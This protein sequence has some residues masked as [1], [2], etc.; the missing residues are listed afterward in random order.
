M[1]IYTETIYTKTTLK[2]ILKQLVAEGEV[3][4][5]SYSI[6]LLITE[7]EATNYFSINFQLNILSLSRKFCVYWHF[8]PLF[9]SQR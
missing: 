2:F 5:G 3:I 6:E 9:T 4:T 8:T 1:E 7:P